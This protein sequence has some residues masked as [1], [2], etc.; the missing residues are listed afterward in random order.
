M[1]T[2]EKQVS[3]FEHVERGFKIVDKIQDV[4]ASI[5]L[6]IMELLMLFVV[7]AAFGGGIYYVNYLGRT[8]LER[9]Y[10]D[11]CV[12]VAGKTGRVLQVE[13]VEPHLD[14]DY[15]PT[16]TGQL[17]IEFKG[18][19]DVFNSRAVTVVPCGA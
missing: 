16:F 19:G 14:P 7:L 9:E 17:V 4:V 15:V 18:S 8:L 3:L 11:K 5:F 12:A 13:T 1:I 10:L 2:Q 6:G